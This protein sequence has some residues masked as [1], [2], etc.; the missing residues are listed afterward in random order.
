M[1]KK[2]GELFKDINDIVL[3]NELFVEKVFIEEVK[4]EKNN[5]DDKFLGNNEV[6]DNK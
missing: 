3:C 4:V 6:M 2:I 5:K 1:D